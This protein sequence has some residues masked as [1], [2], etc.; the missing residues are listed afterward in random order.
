MK[1]RILALTMIFFAIIFTLAAHLPDAKKWH[2]YELVFESTV[3]YENP[4]HDIKNFEVTFTSP[5]GIVKTINGFWLACTAWN[6]ALKSTDSEWNQYLKQRVKN[7]YSVIQFVT[8]QWRG[9]DKSSEGLIAFEGCGRISIN[10]EFFRLID[11]KIDKI[12]EYGLVA[13]PVVL[14]ALTVGAGRELSPGYYL[15]DDQAILLAKYKVARYGGNQVVWM[16]GGDGFYTG[17][18]EQRWKTI[19]RTVFD[20]K[21]QCLVTQHPSGRQWIGEVFKD[22]TWIER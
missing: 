10:P 14:W 20:G 19:G 2:K 5:T 13:A 15:P 12:N 18:H 9:G 22:E 21:H 1:K 17:T 11:K 3:T 4:I 7:E 6:G 16:L 8:T